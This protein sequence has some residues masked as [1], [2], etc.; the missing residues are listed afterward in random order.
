MELC[1]EWR[2]PAAYVNDV[3]DL[4]E[5][6]QYQ[7][8]DYWVKLDHPEAGKQ[9]YAGP[10]FKMSETPIEYKRAPLL[11]EHNEEVYMG[12][13]GL[14]RQGLNELRENGVV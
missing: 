7:A 9:P 5:D 13:L 12:R 10:P 8:R 11:G 14:S 4:L 1:Q 6:K 2:V 3:A